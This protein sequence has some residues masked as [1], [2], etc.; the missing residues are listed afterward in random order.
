MLFKLSCLAGIGLGLADGSITPFWALAG[1]TVT[2]WEKAL[3]FVLWFTVIVGGPWLLFEGKAAMAVIT[4][5]YVAVYL[6]Y[7]L[8]V[9]HIDKKSAAYRYM[10]ALGWL[11]L[12]LQGWLVSGW[13]I[14][15]LSENEL[16]RGPVHYLVATIPAALAAS[17][18]T[19]RTIWNRPRL[20]G[21]VLSEPAEG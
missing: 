15:E 3:R 8:I 18:Y 16:I 12:A 20:Q 4:W 13:L 10:T 9:D 14:T 5:P 2:L 6:V 17:Y 19:V 21:H 11:T 7:L 1:V